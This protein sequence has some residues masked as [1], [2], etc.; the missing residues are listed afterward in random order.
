MATTNS[1]TSEEEDAALSSAS[2]S[3]SPD[4]SPTD[5][6]ELTLFT[7]QT[8][9]LASCRPDVLAAKKRTALIRTVQERIQ[10]DPAARRR[11]AEWKGAYRDFVCVCMD[12]TQLQLEQ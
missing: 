5:A 7:R 6:A 10:T 11:L 1:T 3:D 8:A 9:I 2:D 12:G 4:S